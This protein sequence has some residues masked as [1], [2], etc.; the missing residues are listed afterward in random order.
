[1]LELW[2]FFI[3]NIRKTPKFFERYSR[4]IEKY[5]AKLD[6]ENIGEYKWEYFERIQQLRT[7]HL[8]FS[9]P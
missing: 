3:K 9:E 7:H 8:Y 6:D 5:D 2:I 4:N 1:M